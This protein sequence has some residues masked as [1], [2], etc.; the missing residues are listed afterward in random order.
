VLARGSELPGCFGEKDCDFG[1]Y[2][3]R[4]KRCFSPFVYILRMENDLEELLELPLTSLWYNVS[5]KKSQADISVPKLRLEFCELIELLLQRS[6]ERDCS[7]YLSAQEFKK[8]SN[9]AQMSMM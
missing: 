6:I 7:G 2:R 8:T 4:W 5:Q 1:F 9:Q 3:D